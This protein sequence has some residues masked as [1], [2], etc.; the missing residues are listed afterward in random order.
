MKPRQHNLVEPRA[1]RKVDATMTKRGN[2]KQS[3]KAITVPFAATPRAETLGIAQWAHPLVWTESMLSTLLENKVKGGRWHTLYDKVMSDHNL[4]VSALKVVEKAGA[5][6][7]DRQT[8]KDFAD[9]HRKEIDRLQ[10]ELKDESYRPLPVRRAEIP[11]PGSNEKR[12]L[13]IPTVRDRVVQTALVHVI[14]PIF[15]QTFHDR[16]FGFRHGRGCH[17]AL[18]CVEGLLNDGYVYV[19]DADLKSYF[20]TIPKDRL[21]ELV[22]QK[23][24]DSAVLQLI[25]KYLD[26]QI[27]SELATWT[28]EAGVPQGAVLSPM[29]SNVYL[30]PLDHMMSAKGYQM[31]R[32]ADDFVILCRSQTEAEAALSEVRTWVESAGLSLHPEKTHIV[33]SREKSFAFLGYS[34]RGRFRFPRA[35]SHAKVVDRIRELTPRKSGESLACMIDRL[36]RSLRGWFNYFRHC[37]YNIFAAYDQMIRR[38]LRRLLM[39]RNRKNPKRL[40]RQNRWPNSFFTEQGLYSLSEAHQRFVQSTGTY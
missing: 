21:L 24:S 4:S 32:Y 25:K 36:N 29:L 10:S 8:V 40:P 33:D 35:K 28:P 22:K 7:V 13:G 12:A 9:R 37:F 15:D 16:S 11:K 34:F 2:S 26:Q 19:V 3:Y 39:K 27:M 23:I 31:V 5:A 14:E 6:G 30:N 20:D 1:V 38:R 17:D 18:R